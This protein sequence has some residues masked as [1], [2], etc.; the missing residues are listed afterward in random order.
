MKINPINKTKIKPTLQVIIM[1]TKIKFT[2]LPMK[3]INNL[4]NLNL[5]SI[6]I[7]TNSNRSS[8]SSSTSRRMKQKIKHMQAININLMH[9]ITLLLQITKRELVIKN[10]KIL[11]LKFLTDIKKLDKVIRQ[12]ES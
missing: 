9:N 11:F 6:L 3:I 1:I 7:L 4:I 5:K 12:K 10:Y 8:S 2:Q